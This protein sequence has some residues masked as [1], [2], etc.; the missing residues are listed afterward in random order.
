MSKS[1]RLNPRTIARASTCRLYKP[2]LLSRRSLPRGTPWIP[3]SFEGQP[4][5]PEAKE[6]RDRALVEQARR[7]RKRQRPLPSRGNHRPLQG[8]FPGEQ[9][10][11]VLGAY[12]R[13]QSVDPAVGGRAIRAQRALRRVYVEVVPTIGHL[14]PAG[15]ASPQR[16][17]VKRH[18]EHLVI[19]EADW[20]AR[21]RTCKTQ[22]H[23]HAHCAHC[24]WRMC[25]LGSPEISLGSKDSTSLE[26]MN[27]NN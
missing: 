15:A 12:V 1:R 23:L 27:L 16:R 25:A 7:R 22:Q 9:Y 5:Q 21:H 19:R 13:A 14:L 18:G 20:H 4:G 17:V 11:P 3:R 10:L 24:I 26:S 2:T 8:P 6:G